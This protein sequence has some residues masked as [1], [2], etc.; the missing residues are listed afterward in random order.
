MILSTRL[1]F[2]VSIFCLS[3]QMH[4]NA[5]NKSFIAGYKNGLRI[6]LE[7]AIRLSKIK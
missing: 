3:A 4:S 2:L 5:Q 7:E 6:D 1:K